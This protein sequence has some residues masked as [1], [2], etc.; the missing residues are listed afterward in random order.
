MKRY[1][2]FA[3]VD[4]CILMDM[5]TGK[6]VGSIIPQGN[7][8]CIIRYGHHPESEPMKEDVIDFHITGRT[9]LFA[10]AGA[11]CGRLHITDDDSTV[12]FCYSDECSLKGVY[13]DA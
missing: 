1:I 9:T 7:G 6:P 12:L 2:W 4:C 11:I 5:K 8:D 10:A 3:A 13:E